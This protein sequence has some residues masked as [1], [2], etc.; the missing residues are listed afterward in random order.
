MTHR[1]AIL[2]PAAI[3]GLLRAIDSFDGQ[4]TTRAALQLAA[5]LFVRPG[6]LRH[7]EFAR[8]FIHSELDAGCE[9]PESRS[10]LAGF[11]EDIMRRRA[12]LLAAVLTIWRWARQNATDLDR[13]SY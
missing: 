12:E 4:P 8:R 3:G 13:G 1:S 2:D 5:Y 10:F 11:L 9:D 6:E 7:A